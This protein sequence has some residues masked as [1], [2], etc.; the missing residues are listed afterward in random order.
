MS[1]KTIKTGIL[2]RTLNFSRADA[3]AD[4]RTLELSFSS[5]DPYDRYWGTE[6]LDHSKKSVD[7]SRLNKGGA[8]LMDH[9]TKDQIGVIEKAYIGSDRKGR[10]LVRFGKA[11]RAN[12]VFQDVLDGI[13][14]NVSVGYIIHRMRQE[15]SD[16]ETPIFRATKWEPLEVS[17]VSVPA[18]VSVGVGRSKADLEFETVVK[19]LAKEKKTMPDDKNKEPDTKQAP[20]AVDTSAI[21]A[22]AAGDAAKKEQARIR[23]IIAYGDEFECKDLA[24]KAIESGTSVNDFRAGIL[25]K[26]KKSVKPVETDGGDLGLTDTEAQSF[27]FLRAIN[28]MANPHDRTSQEA[29]AFEFEVS[30]AYA[31][32]V[33]RDP[34]GVFVPPEVLRRD[35]TVGTNTAGGYTVAT[36][37]LAANFIELLR[38]RMVVKQAGAT[39]LSGLVGDIAIPKQ[40]G[41]ATAYW[42]A[43]SGAPTESQQT[44]GQLALTPKTV[45][46]YT[47]LSRK[48]L[49]QS[50][51]D[52][53][54]LVRTDLATVLAIA[55][56]LAS[57]HGSGAG[58]QPT[59]I[60]STTSIGSVAGGTN[61]LAPAWS[62][63]VS[64]ETEI[65]QDNADV[66][67]LAYI[68]NA[69]VRGKLKTVYTNATYGEIPV[70]QTGSGGVG[71]LNGYPAYVTNQVSSTLTKGSASGT[72]SAIFYG[73]WADLIIGM[74]GGVDILADPYTNSTS[75]TVRVVA[76]SDVDL[77]VRH[78]ESFAAMLD[79]LTA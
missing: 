4:E 73:N 42:V 9:N 64:L 38:N 48:L 75:G 26:M 22:K 62:H 72:C 51:I 11:Q 16:P 63:I 47:D 71:S 41:G 30:K 37:L 3:N 57:L 1:E 70:W 35:L 8:L 13:R 10:A 15:E 50:S 61:G 24:M 2:Q 18:D 55:I 23:E 25:D 54:N 36:D 7:L 67:N 32:K 74:W 40:T 6:I 21:E 33:R 17:L 43:E 79:A 65:A 14:Q 19:P 77:G 34:Q 68:T 78:A 12:E 66:G 76:L 69:K 45:G 60:A 53:E 28:A 59:G 29:A 49:L 27:S 31:E 46:A 5:E 20:P 39:V 44:F 56:D 58:N 52:I